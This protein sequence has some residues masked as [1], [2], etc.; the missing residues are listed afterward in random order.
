MRPTLPNRFTTT[1]RAATPMHAIPTAAG[2]EGIT[3]KLCQ[4]FA[5][6]QGCPS[7]RKCQYEHPRDYP[8]KCFICG[9]INHISRD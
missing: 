5:T 6:D 4:R 8:W 3:R 1:N 2:V 9:S 7:G